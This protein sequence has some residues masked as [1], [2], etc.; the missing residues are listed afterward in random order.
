MTNRVGG[1][2]SF[3]PECGMERQ[4]SDRLMFPG[5]LAFQ[6]KPFII[7]DLSLDCPLSKMQNFLTYPMKSWTAMFNKILRVH[8]VL[9]YIFFKADCR[10][11]DCIQP[12]HI[13]ES[14]RKVDPGS[15]AYL[16]YTS[17]TYH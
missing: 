1:K 13:K 14:L 10:K 16:R 17:S 9:D 4:G 5:S 6:T 12:R 7:I 11:E 3:C 8:Q 2:I 15:T